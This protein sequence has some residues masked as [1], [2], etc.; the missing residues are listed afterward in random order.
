MHLCFLFLC[1]LFTPPSPLPP[2]ASPSSSFYASLLLLPPSTSLSSSLYASL[3]LL[4]PLPPP[5]SMPPSSSFLLLPST[6]LSCTSRSSITVIKSLAFVTQ[7]R[8]ELCELTAGGDIV[9]QGR[10][11]RATGE[12]LGGGKSLLTQGPIRK[13]NQGMMALFPHLLF[14]PG[15]IQG[16]PFLLS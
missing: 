5:P 16:M 3:F 15:P 9:H 7:E 14:S 13:Q 2:F 8:K 10:E 1:P 4:P 11:G 12:V 6:P